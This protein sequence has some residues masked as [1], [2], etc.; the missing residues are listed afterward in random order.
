[1]SAEQVRETLQQDVEVL[2]ARGEYGRFLTTTSSSRSWAPT[3]RRGVPRRPS[4]RSASCTDG[5]RRRAR[6]HQPGG[7]RPRRGRRG[8]LRRHT[9]T[10]DFSGVAQPAIPSA[11]RTRCSMTSMP[12]RSRR[13][14]STCRWTSASLRS[15]ARPN[16]TWPLLGPKGAAGAA[17]EDSTARAAPCRAKRHAAR[18]AGSGGL[19][20]PCSR[21]SAGVS[22]LSEGAILDA[23][24]GTRDETSANS[25]S[26]ER[27]GSP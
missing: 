12:T 21:P 24:G 11:F 18:Q 26:S 16:Q 25:T 9:H 4:R 6:D 5:L 20:L 1:M 15:A 13:C 2:L 8:V 3:S 23:D 7:G 10:G 19:A 14:G 17:A 22:S 27:Q